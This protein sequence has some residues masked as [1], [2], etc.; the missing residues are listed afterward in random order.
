[1]SNP[2]RVLFL[3]SEAAPFVKVGGLGDVAGSLPQVLR[4]LPDAPDYA[5]YTDWDTHETKNDRMHGR[6]VDCSV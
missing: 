4:A 5:D 6:T 1:M 2:V 3:A